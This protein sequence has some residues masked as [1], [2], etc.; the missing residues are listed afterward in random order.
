MHYDWVVPMLKVFLFVIFCQFITAC[1]A[2]LTPALLQDIE[3]GQS[4]DTVLAHIKQQPLKVIHTSYNG[5]NYVVYH[6]PLRIGTRTSL[7]Y[8]SP[9]VYSSRKEPIVAPYLLIF[10]LANSTE[11]AAFGTVEALQ[12]SNTGNV[13]EL[14]QQLE[15]T[16]GK[17]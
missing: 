7:V 11:L 13:R 10:K 5:D 8:R 17:F 14:I 12:N 6:Y 15:V 4:R 9:G 3:I 2:P 1:T 16:Y